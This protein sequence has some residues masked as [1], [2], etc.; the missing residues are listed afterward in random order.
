MKKKLFTMFMLT[1]L[2]FSMAACSKKENNTKEM[3]TD[4]AD[5]T[6][7]E[8]VES[9]KGTT[10][11]FYGWGGDEQL[12]Q[13]LDNEFAPLMKE[14]YDITMER[15]PMDIDQVLS[16]LSGEVQAGKEKGS[17]DMIWINGENFQSAKENNMLYGPFVDKL[18]NYNE[19]I[20]TES[21]DV[22]LDFA[23]PIEGFEAPYG[24][25]QI[26]MIADTAVVTELPTSTEALM[27]FVKKNPGKVTYPALPD[28]TGSAFVRNV[29]YD[30]CGYEQFLTMEADKEVVKEAIEPALEYLRQ[31]NPYLWNQ[32]TTFPNSSTTL[33]NMF[34][35]GEVLLNMSY[36]A[37][38]TAIKIENGTYTET[39]QTFQ[40]DKGTIGNTNFM[41]IAVNA[42]NK[43]GAMVAIN[44]MISPEVQADRYDELKVLPVVD[45]DKLND[46]QK[47]AFD[48]VDLGKGTIPQDELLEKRL[49][50]MKA[51]LVPIIE[52]IWEE[53]VVGK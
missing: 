14:K 34:A 20:D 17:I 36:D 29:I 39:T 46:T 13:W 3:E 15:V 22:T 24:K 40:F 12:N 31:L 44:E 1:V 8:M 4:I 18:P 30:I 53:E 49:P 19:Y 42:P 41:A 25:A 50:E 33:D 26:V 21:E 10:V 37:Y 32:G 2:L 27:E 47:E 11:T 52:E 48:K 35:D 28:F 7:E 38:G 6:F 51:E 45:Y 23:Y 9:A 16:Q 43:A 5:M